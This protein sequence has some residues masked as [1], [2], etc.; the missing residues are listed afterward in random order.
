MTSTFGSTHL[1]ESA[2]SNMSFIKYHHHSSLTDDYLLSLLRLAT[3]EIQVDIQFGGRE[4]ASSV[5]T[6][7]TSFINLQLKL[8]CPNE[9]LYIFEL[10]FSF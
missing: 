3:T 5:F 7:T 6:L 2:F 9:L 4:Q 10:A 8:N 1:C